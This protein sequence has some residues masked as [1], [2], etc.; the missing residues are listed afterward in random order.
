MAIITWNEGL[1]VNI[2][3]I[4]DQHKVLIRIINELH[5]AMMK[6]KSKDILESSITELVDY[7]KKHFKTE[8]ELFDKYS[9]PKTGQHKKQH[10][11]F[12]ERIKDFQ[13][14]H[15]TGGAFLS[16][17]IMEFLKDWLTN[18]IVGTDKEYTEFFHSKG[19]K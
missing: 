15:K 14:K 16:I 3:E 17:E 13:E 5:D 12:V 11:I 4:D 19:I 1:S 8:E 6:G 2:K 9:Y 18:H 7:T 10:D